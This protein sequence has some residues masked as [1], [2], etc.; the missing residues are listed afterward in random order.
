MFTK[1]YM[2]Q[3]QALVDLSVA[4]GRWCCGAATLIGSRDTAATVVTSPSNRTQAPS[5]HPAP[6][7]H[8]PTPRG[9]R[10]PPSQRP[11][12][13]H[14]ALETPQTLNPPPR[15]S[16][17]GPP[18]L[19]VRPC[20][21]IPSALQPHLLWDYLVRTQPVPS[22]RLPA[23]IPSGPQPVF[24]YPSERCVGPSIEQPN[25]TE[26]DTISFAFQRYS[27]TVPIHSSFRH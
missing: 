15:F 8:S 9:N 3:V 26:A 2:V 13:R 18:L 17:E 1:N 14:P 11:P 20:H 16:S 19:A 5:Q 27:T 6:C 22:A 25:L 7:R 24:T 10:S 4:P 21:W 23:S 12:F